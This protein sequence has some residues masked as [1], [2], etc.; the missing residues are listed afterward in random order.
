MYGVNSSYLAIDMEEGKEV[1]WNEIEVQLDY[2]C[3]TVIDS[4]M[5]LVVVS[6]FSLY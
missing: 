5:V 6:I 1:V 2:F 3:I 4:I